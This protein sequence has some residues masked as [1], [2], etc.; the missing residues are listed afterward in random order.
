MKITSLD[1]NSKGISRWSIQEKLS[2]IRTNSK[3]M[4]KKRS[5]VNQIKIVQL[6]LLRKTTKI[7]QRHEMRNSTQK[8]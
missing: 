2:N 4:M 5:Q 7:Q 1:I 6:I 8:N 3:G